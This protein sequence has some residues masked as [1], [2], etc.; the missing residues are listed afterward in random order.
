MQIIFQIA[1]GWGRQ[2]LLVDVGLQVEGV[3]KGVFVGVEVYTELQREERY[4]SVGEEQIAQRFLEVVCEE[5]VYDVWREQVFENTVW[6]GGSELSVVV[7]IFVVELDFVSVVVQ[8]SSGMTME[9]ISAT[10]T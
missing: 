5:G 7:A 3:Q 4:V 10:W 2:M 1:R 9:A 8:E 6:R